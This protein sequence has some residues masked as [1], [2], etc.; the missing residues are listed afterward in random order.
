MI[1]ARHRAAAVASVLTTLLLAGCGGE[2]G[3]PDSTP[4][5]AVVLSENQPSSIEGVQVVATSVDG[6]SATLSVTAQGPATETDVTE[7]ADVTIGDASFRVEAVWSEG[8]GD[9]PG[10]MGGRVMVV[11]A[12]G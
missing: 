1:A 8:D 3:A 6:D 2:S 12:D 10:G 7:G 5:G 11:P 9:Q 4:A